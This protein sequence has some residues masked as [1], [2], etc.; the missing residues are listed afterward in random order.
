VKR[1]HGSLD[2]ATMNL[3]LSQPAIQFVEP[4]AT[5]RP[6]LVSPQSVASCG[7]VTV[8]GSGFAPASSVQVLLKG[9]GTVLGTLTVS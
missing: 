3:A 7:S 6:L 5:L 8:D 9:T 1:I 2:E 4:A